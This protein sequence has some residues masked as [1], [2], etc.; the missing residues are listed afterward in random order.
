MELSHAP[1]GGQR[2]THDHTFWQGMWPQPAPILPRH[3]QGGR[4]EIIGPRSWQFF[5][6]PLDVRR[7]HQITWKA[8][9]CP[10]EKQKPPPLGLS[11]KRGVYE[12]KRL[13]HKEAKLNIVKCII[14]T[15]WLLT[16]RYVKIV[17]P[18]DWDRNRTCIWA[19]GRMES[20]ALC[21][22]NWPREGLRSF[23]YTPSTR[24]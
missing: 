10:L 6:T 16:I 1:W 3:R 23:P 15:T 4:R 9:I 8:G 2:P 24:T 13:V 22:I 11:G 7:C 18:R 19:E 14:W 20:N 5:L 12:A 21:L 17:S